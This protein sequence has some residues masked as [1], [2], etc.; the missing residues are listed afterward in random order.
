MVRGRVEVL[1][2]HAAFD[3]SSALLH[4]PDE[5]NVMHH[6]ARIHSLTECAGAAEEDVAE[7]LH[8]DHPAHVIGCMRQT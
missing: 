7:E 8:D 3:L 4:M 1:Q 6:T 5:A 2:R